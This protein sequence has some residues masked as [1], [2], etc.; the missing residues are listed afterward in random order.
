[1]SKQSHNQNHSIE[2]SVDSTHK[3]IILAAANVFIENGYARSTTRSLAD[4]AGITEA[5]LFRH[6]GSKEALFKEVIQS[7]GGR[8]LSNEFEQLLSG[9]Y[10][11]D[12]HRLGQAFL[13]ISMERGR[14][15]R[16]ILF[17]ADHFPELSEALALNPREFR[18]MLSRYLDH[19]IELG[20][21]RPMHTEAAA[22]AFWGMILAYSLA[23]D[24]MEGISGGMSPEDAVTHFVNLFINGTINQE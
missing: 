18:A 10:S 6:F 11:A 14:I 4:A 13:H 22:Q 20:I 7:F 1:M 2:S 21:A 15:M 8:T 23:V 16:L 3:R 24:T 9:D 5:T 19:Q 12:L 17:E